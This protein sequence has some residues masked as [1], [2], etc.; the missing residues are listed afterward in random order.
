MNKCCPFCKINVG[1]SSH[2]YRCKKRN[3]TLS[4][5]DI[6]FE[7]ICF[8]F[9][10]LTKEILHDRYCIK[11]QSLVQIKSEFEIDYNST[12]FLLDYF[13]FDK[14]GQSAAAKNC[15][16]QKILTSL[17]RYGSINPLSKDTEPYKKRNLTVKGKYGVSN[18]FE[19]EYAKK[20]IIEKWPETKIKRE[21]ALLDNYGWSSPFQVPSILKQALSKSKIQKNGLYKKIASRLENIGINF[22]TEFILKTNNRSY[23]YDFLIGTKIVELNGD[24]W[25]ANPEKYRADDLIIYPGK[26]ILRAAEVWKKDEE[27]IHCANNA[28]FEVLI[29]WEKEINKTPDNVVL[30][31]LESLK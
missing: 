5:S 14:R 15:G 25:H 8:N 24:Y 9:P 11:M 7:Y 13:K 28:G 4:K 3:L 6:K 19:T 10:L 16:P 29:F 2:I 18:I 23:F 30:K 31:I 26:R 20:I 12:I 21:R 1:P 27:K 17:E 22:E